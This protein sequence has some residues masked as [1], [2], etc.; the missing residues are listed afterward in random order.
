ME[1]FNKLKSF[2]STINL[3]IYIQSLEMNSESES[4]SSSSKKTSTIRLRDEQVNEESSLSEGGSTD[5]SFNV[6]YGDERGKGMEAMKKNPLVP[7]GALLTAGVL[8]GGLVAFQ[9]G[10]S[11][12]S[13]KLMR[14]RVLAQGATL[15]VLATSVIGMQAAKG[16]GQADG[17]KDRQVDEDDDKCRRWNT[18]TRF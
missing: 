13:Q 3:D 10:N 5:P 9:R 18:Y 1:S 15:A 12:L 17:Q 8:F 6:I 7:A 4:S 11:I 2:S 14:A 16:D